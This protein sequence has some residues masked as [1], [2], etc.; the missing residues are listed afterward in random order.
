MKTALTRLALF[1]WPFALVAISGIEPTYD[2]GNLTAALCLLAYVL[3]STIA[4]LFLDKPT[5]CK[6]MARFE[7]RIARI[8]GI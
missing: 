7:K 5:A 8:L 3:I 6:E 1:N 4:L 2:A